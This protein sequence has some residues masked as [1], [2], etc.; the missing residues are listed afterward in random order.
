M[1]ASAKKNDWSARGGSGWLLTNPAKLLML[2]NF[3]RD[4]CM[5]VCMYG[6]HI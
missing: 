4:A 2:Y 6:H 3:P 5:Y 1:F